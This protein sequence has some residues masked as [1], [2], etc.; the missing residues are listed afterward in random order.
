[1]TAP[2]SVS[3]PTTAKE[4]FSGPADI[5]DAARIAAAAKF[6]TRN[7]AWSRWLVEAILEKLQT[8]RPDLYQ[9]V[10]ATHGADPAPELTELI[11]KIQAA[12]AASPRILRR[13]DRALRDELRQP[14]SA[15]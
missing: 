1:M 3:T 14:K 5:M 9:A 11:A 8:D 15:A 6:G 2:I 13:V 4:S 10:R 12:Y 7:G